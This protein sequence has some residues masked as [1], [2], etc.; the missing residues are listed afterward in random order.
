MEIWRENHTWAHKEGRKGILPPSL[1]VMDGGTGPVTVL[2]SSSKKISHRLSFNSIPCLFRI[3]NTGMLKHVLQPS[4]AQKDSPG[5]YIRQV[6][7]DGAY[8]LALSDQVVDVRQHI[9]ALISTNNE[10]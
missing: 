2:G 9:S 6:L 7:R 4:D 8:E 5:A 3:S 1:V 10:T